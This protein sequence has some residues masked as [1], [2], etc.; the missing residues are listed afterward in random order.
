MLMTLQ[1]ALAKSNANIQ[2]LQET[3]KNQINDM[4]TI[5]KEREILIEELDIA[6]NELSKSR[7]N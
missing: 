4:S 3:L 5:V 6:E 7:L 1:T 2:V